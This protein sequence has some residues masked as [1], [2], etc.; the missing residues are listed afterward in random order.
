MLS[1]VV[2]QDSPLTGDAERMAE[3]ITQDHLKNLIKP[4]AFAGVVRRAS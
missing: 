2:Q 1:E 3:V 4:S